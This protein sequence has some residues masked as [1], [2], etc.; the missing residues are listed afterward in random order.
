MNALRHA[1]LFILVAALPAL[2]SPASAAAEAA[3]N[4]PATTA[5]AAAPQWMPRPQAE[6][7]VRNAYRQMLNRE[8]DPS[9]FTTFVKALVVDG[10]DRAWL[11]RAFRDSPERRSVV[12]GRWLRARL[13]GPIAILVV[14]AW[15]WRRRRVAR[16]DGAIGPGG[17]EPA[18]RQATDLLAVVALAALATWTCWER[19]PSL[20]FAL[21]ALQLVTYLLF[22]FLPGF[23]LLRLGR[24][25][26]TVDDA[27]MYAIPVSMAITSAVFVLLQVLQ[28]PA[29]AFTAVLG[30]TGIAIAAAAWKAHRV[31]DVR[32][33]GG[34]TRFGLLLVLLAALMALSFVAVGT[35]WPADE[36]RSGLQ[37]AHRGFHDMPPDNSLQ[38]DTAN[39]FIRHEP[40]WTW[41]PGSW[42]MGDRTPMMAVQQSVVFRTLG[43]R[44]SFW[45]YEVLGVLFNSLFLLPLVRLARRMFPGPNL[46]LVVTAMVM[47]NGFAFLNLY[48]TWPKLMGVFFMLQ[49]VLLLAEPGGSAL[50]FGAIGGMSAFAMLCHPGN[51]LSLPMLG[52]FYGV[53][54]LRRHRWRT[55]GYGGAFLA[56]FLA[57]ALPWTL[58]RHAHPEINT[59]KLL[60]TY[61]DEAYVDDMFRSA[62]QKAVLMRYLTDT[63]PGDLLRKHAANVA[64]LFRNNLWD[65]A[66]SMLT[67][68]W[69]AYQSALFPTDFF[70]LLPALGQELVWLALTAVFLV[71]LRRR[72]SRSAAPMPWR[73]GELAF[74][75]GWVVLSYLLNAFTKAGFPAIHELP[76]TEYVLLLV[77]T[78]GLACSMSVWTMGLAIGFTV[79]RL[80]YTLLHTA[81][82][83]G[84]FPLDFFNAMVLAMPLLA[85]AWILRNRLPSR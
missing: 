65:A 39:V 25:P 73:T 31:A 23:Y 33:L 6:A 76:V 53:R 71:P 24:R 12:H 46:P 8:P 42:N 55:L 52:L 82:Y 74:T 15:A 85:F 4:I 72:F 36:I 80:S 19:A 84:F 29:I 11:Q 27:A 83:R 45:D 44:C 51:L 28:A 50:R 20:A 57:C 58:Y 49:A 63:A 48:Y 41:G 32:M 70:S 59:N 14:A 2:A 18:W 81:L 47:L 43:Q 17:S 35:T 54:V 13:A 22:F 38:F 62:D 69:N 78:T 56:V 40:P 64:V 16:I 5:E 30:L 77:I 1:V 26:L 66:H 75:A 67:G 37:V 9:G 10:R 34:D 79:L 3:T 60:I 68:D 7:I 61:V 21:M